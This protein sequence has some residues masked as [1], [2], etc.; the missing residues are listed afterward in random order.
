[1]VSIATIA[2]VAA[3]AEVARRHGPF[4]ARVALIVPWMFAALVTVIAGVLVGRWRSGNR[5]SWLLVLAGWLMLMRLLQWSNNAAAYTLGGVIGG[6]AVAVLIH[7]V[8][9][10]PTGR[11][12]TATDRGLVAVVYTIAATSSIVPNLF[13]ECL[14]DF[15]FGCPQNLLVI[16]PDR[17]RVELAERIGDAAGFAALL[18][19]SARL[20]VRWHGAS[21][22]LRRILSL[23][24]AAGAAFL[25][26]MFLGVTTAWDRH[27]DLAIIVEP[28]VVS[29]L[30]IAVLLGIVSSKARA[31]DIGA[32]V[33]SVPASRVG[34]RELVPLLAAAS[35]DHSIEL[36]DVDSDGEPGAP[37]RRGR[38]RASVDTAH[39]VLAVIEYD[40]AL[41]A[42]PEVVSALVAT[43]RLA[44]ENAALAARVA[45]QLDE[46][47]ASRA[48]LL[49]AQQD[50]RRR[51]E[52][53]LHDGA[54]QHLVTA[55]LLLRMATR[56]GGDAALVQNVA[57]EI[58]VAVR[59]LRALSHG[60][61]PTLVS[62][63][64]LSAAVQSLAEHAALP[65]DVVGS[66][67]RLPPMVEAVAYFVV[68]EA[69]TNVAKHAGADG[70]TVSLGCED[71]TLIVEIVDDGSGGADPSR[72]S[73]I[74]GLRDRVEAAGGELTIASTSG[75]GTVVTARLPA[76]GGRAATRVGT[77]G[78]L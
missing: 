18:A 13:H 3:L 49:Q 50:E 12:P 60:L 25:A 58:E 67:G 56:A 34:K 41:D 44:L 30:P 65:V 38:S 66:V 10:L 77:E 16:D 24:Y 20:A 62:E 19:V 57:E 61:H 11:L 40:E 15:G 59:E 70:A 28:L 1:M 47:Q 14:N 2:A 31:G 23:P 68:A 78:A 32:L 75:G 73:G 27:E 42:E 9:A 4:P 29:L 5:T 72:G 21:P 54:Q 46:V 43:A 71:E 33:T 45:R 64:G 36:V 39:G 17:N 8:L 26:I 51:I 35:G 22:S 52:R 48:R 37:L 63:R 74:V 55:Q 76:S 7:V 6:I 53:N 69:L